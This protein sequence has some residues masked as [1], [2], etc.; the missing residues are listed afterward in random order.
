MSINKKYLDLWP[1]NVI[2]YIKM[3]DYEAAKYEADRLMA[4]LTDELGFRKLSYKFWKLIGLGRS[5]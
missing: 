1:Q 2:P 5:R 4:Q 3:K